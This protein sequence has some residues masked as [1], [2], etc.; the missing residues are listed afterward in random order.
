MEVVFDSGSSFTYFAAQPYQVL[1]TAASFRSFSP[2][3]Q[4]DSRMKYEAN[5][6]LFLAA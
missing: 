2:V 4:H 5:D 6:V 3:M 1:V